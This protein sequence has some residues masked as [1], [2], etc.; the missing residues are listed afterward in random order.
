MNNNNEVI[1]NDDYISLRK[2]A[3]NAN[4]IVLHCENNLCSNNYE[5]ATVQWSFDED[6]MWLLHLRCK[7]CKRQWNICCMCTNF[8]VRMT[9]KKQV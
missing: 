8:K 5:N 4:D 1:D 2:R 7:V 3:P 9:T 6:I